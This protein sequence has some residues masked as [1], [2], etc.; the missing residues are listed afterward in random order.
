MKV[1]TWVEVTRDLS[2]YSNVYVRVTKGG[3]GTAARCIDNLILTY[4]PGTQYAITTASVENG[5]IEV[6]K[7]TAEEDDAITLTETPNDGYKFDGWNVYKT[8]DSETKVTV[9]NNAFT[10]PAYDVTVSALFSARVATTIIWHHGKNGAQTKSTNTY[11]D[12]TLGTLEEANAVN[13]WTFVGWTTQS[14]V[15]AST[16]PTLVTTS[17]VVGE[18]TDLYA[19]Y[20]NGEDKFQLVTST[21]GIH[22]GDICMIGAAGYYF[23]NYNGSSCGR[24]SS[25]QSLTEGQFTY[26]E[27]TK[28]ILEAKGYNWAFKTSEGKY[29]T[30]EAKSG[31]SAPLSFADSYTGTYDKWSL[32]FDEGYAVINNV[33]GN[34]LNISYYNSVFNTYDNKVVYLFMAAGTLQYSITPVAET[35]KVTYDANGADSGDVPTDANEYDPNTE[36]TVLTNSGSLTK[37]GYDFTGWNTASD[38]DGTHYAAD[39]TAKFN[40]TMNTTLYAEWTAQEFAVAVASNSDATIT[41]T[42]A[43]ASAITE[44]FNAGVAFGTTVTLAYSEVVAGR[45]FDG[46]DV[47]KYGEETTK[48]TVTGNT[49]VVPAY[50]VVVTAKFIDDPYLYATLTN[51]NITGSSI[52]GSYATGSI[53]NTYGT[54]NYNACKQSK[55][56]VTYMQIRSNSTFSYLQIPAQAGMLAKVTLHN[57]R[58]GNNGQYSGTVYFRTSLTNSTSEYVASAISEEAGDDVVL[59]IPTG[60]Q[61]GYIMSS[62]PCRFESVTVAYEE[63]S[64][65]KTISA[66]KMATMYLPYNVTIPEG[67][68]AYWVDGSGVDKDITLTKIT[69]GVIPAYTGVIVYADVDAATPFNFDVTAEEGSKYSNLLLGVTEKT[70]WNEISNYDEKLTYYALNVVEGT[71]VFSQVTGGSYAANSAFLGLYLGESSVKTLS[72]SFDDETGVASL[73]TINDQEPTAI[74]NLAG[75]RVNK[76]VKGQMYI[77]NGQKVLR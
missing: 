66:Y 25:T 50:A 15:S 20:S 13:G 61:T 31:S 5:A 30:S 38:G 36:V 22:D 60:Y 39:G 21:E 43:G 7:A 8:G 72:I 4:T 67:V 6:S 17:T 14:S 70:V 75:Q 64:Y 9:T 3:T 19:V 49:F 47:Y 73:S 35:I 58:N 44:G 33:D 74:Y 28:L 37:T 57:V 18:I 46:W 1:G 26:S 56:D 29:L 16:V 68:K 52:T 62:D 2:S 42:P 27:G 34:E 65:A 24:T 63:Y 55:D 76:M 69:D 45:L 10:M 32:S 59:S 51:A 53:T 23:L 11:T 77:I 48:V 41:A 54:W 71:V 40:I 12:A